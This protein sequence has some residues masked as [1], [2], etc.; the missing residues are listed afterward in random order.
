MPT[1][2]MILNFGP[3]HPATHGTL[4]IVLELDGERVVKATPQLGYLHSGF[5]KL[6]EYRSYNQ[7]ITLS[8]RMNY[9][10]PL[11]NNIGF[12]LAVEKLMGLQLTPRCLHVRTILAE[13]SRIADHLLSV[14]TAALDI[15]AFTA[16]LYGFRARE[17]LYDVFEAVTGTRLTTSYTRVGGLLRDVPPEF[18]GMVRNGVMESVKALDEIDRLLTHN[19]IWLGRTR[20]VGYISGPDAIACGLTGPVLRA[21]GVEWDIRKA[22]PYLLY[23]QLDFDIPIGE[24]GDVYDRYLVR[25]EE[26]RQSAKIVLQALDRLPDGPVNANTPHTVLPSKQDVYHS[27][28]ALIYH[29][30]LTMEGHGPEPP[31]GEVYSSTEA[32]NGELGFYLVSDGSRHPYRLRVRPPSFIHFSALPRMIEGGMLADIVAVLGSLNVIAG[33]LDR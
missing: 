2:T 17:V 15:G 29:F 7:F 9:L 25:C 10:S 24:N 19:R 14:G 5:E 28:E 21:S 23:D 6:G 12:A 18:D 13:L 30:K 8:D 3:Q 11:S 4:H 33:E 1:E 32:P 16:F 26:I 22:E 27:M 20:G 31:V